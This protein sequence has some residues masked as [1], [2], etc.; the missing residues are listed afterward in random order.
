MCEIGHR[1]R[2]RS[3]S[4]GIGIALLAG[5]LLAIGSPT[6]AQI[7]KTEESPYT[8]PSDQGLVVFTRPRRRQASETGIRVLTQSGRCIARLENDWQMATPLWP[9]KHMLILLTGTAPPVVQLLQVK[10]SAGKTYVV[11]LRTRVNVKRPVE[12][13]ILR[14]SEQ[15]LEAF[16]AA[17]RERMPSRT[18]LRQCSEWVS[19]KRSKIEPKA[20]IAKGDWDEASDGFRNAHTVRRNDGWTAAEVAAP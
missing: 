14:R 3:A 9:G 11:N 12:V 7:P 15:A 19:W 5:A 20:E 17:V 13:Q 4:A 10:V 6:G 2:P 8:A 1:M 16:P 18:D